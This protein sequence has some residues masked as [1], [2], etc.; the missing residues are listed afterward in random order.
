MGPFFL[1]AGSQRAV[2]EGE[3]W[4]QDLQ[5]WRPSSPHSYSSVIPKWSSLTWWSGW[6]FRK[7]HPNLWGLAA[8]EALLTNIQA[9]HTA[10][11]S[12]SGNCAPSCSPTSLCPDLIPPLYL[13]FAWPFS[14][15]IQVQC[16]SQ[17]FLAQPSLTASHNFGPFLPSDSS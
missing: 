3:L 5:A 15:H 4:A 12:S 17:G 16:I 2:L 9:L 8:T 13:C 1:V 11:A 7:D 6:P 10:L 14:V